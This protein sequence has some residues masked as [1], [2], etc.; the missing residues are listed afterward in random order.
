MLSNTL[1]PI[2]SNV[3]REPVEEW[4][5]HVRDGN[6]SCAK[7][8]AIST[9]SLVKE[10]VI[11]DGLPTV[12][13]KILPKKRNNKYVIVVI[14]GNPGLVEFYDDF[15]A[16]LFNSLHGQSPVYAISHAGRH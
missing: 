14:P 5:R 13:S 1:E 16:T 3:Q 11:V 4:I 2:D 8:A 15:V 6:I 12:V 7:M 9:T 10:V